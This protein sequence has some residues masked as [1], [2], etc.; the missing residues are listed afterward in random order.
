[1]PRTLTLA[2]E[3]HLSLITLNRP[4]RRNAISME[5]LD[6]LLAAL[7][8]C[9]EHW[10]GRGGAVAVTGAGAAFC[11]GM[12]IEMLRELG[13]MGPAHAITDAQKMARLFQRL[14][15]FPLPTI[16]AVNG[17]AVAGG[18]GLASVCDFTLAVPAARFGYTEVRIGFL[19]ALVATYLLRQIG[20]KRVRDLLL[21]GRLISAAEA[22]AWGLVTQVV[23]EQELLTHVRQ[24]AAELA[25]N[26][27]ASLRATKQLLQDLPIYA[28]TEA[29]SMAAKANAAMRTTA[30]FRE[31]LAAFLEKRPPHWTQS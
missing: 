15:E 11:A 31:G 25:R 2:H 9:A 26:S 14:Y 20:E 7:D 28:R 13:R 23:P 22:E 18:C 4:E 6:E 12:D 8:A 27:P 30:D 29:L 21:T 5:L 16:A 1:M 17:A 24:L 19:P 3:E 10:G